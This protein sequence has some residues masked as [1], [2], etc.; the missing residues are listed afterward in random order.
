MRR[1]VSLSLA[2][3]PFGVVSAVIVDTAFTYR[4]TAP[5]ASGVQLGELNRNNISLARY[6]CLGLDAEEGG[7]VLANS[8]ATVAKDASHRVEVCSVSL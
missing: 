1:S 4:R 6:V 5:A 2:R 3:S 8:T 7:R